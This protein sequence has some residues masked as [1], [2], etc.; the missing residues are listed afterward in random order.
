MDDNIKFILKHEYDVFIE[1]AHEEK[2]FHKK[3]SLFAKANR[4][5]LK[6]HKLRDKKKGS[7]NER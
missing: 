5:Y 2:D 1:Q 6:Y 4:I 3:M 7:K